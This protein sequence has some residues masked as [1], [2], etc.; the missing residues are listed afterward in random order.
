MKKQQVKKITQALATSFSLGLVVLF[1]GHGCS[2]IGS[3]KSASGPSASL[4]LAGTDDIQVF[5]NTKTVSTVY[6]KQFM[7]NM[8]SCTGIGIESTL[9]REE[10]K[11]Q[12]ASLSEYGY[13]TDVTPPML[14]AISTM[15]GEV[16]SDVIDGWTDPSPQKRQ[17]LFD[18]FAM[19]R[20]PN[21]TEV[22]GAIQKIAL[23]CW[24]RRATD[25]E[26]S[27]IENMVNDTANGNGETAALVLCTAMLSSYKAIEM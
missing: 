17:V 8:I 6:A 12:K 7:D 24:N 9:T 26:V 15:A 3:V 13:A 22:Q 10:Y 18:N 27:T 2:E 11:A 1:V 4:D 16:C 14:M 5:P 21:A 23:S 25:T 20:A 19:N